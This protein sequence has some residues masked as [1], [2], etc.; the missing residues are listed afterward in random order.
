MRNERVGRF[1]DSSRRALRSRVRRESAVARA[2]RGLFPKLTLKK[3]GDREKINLIGEDRNRPIIERCGE[4]NRGLSR[5]NPGSRGLISAGRPFCARARAAA[6]IRSQRHAVAWLFSV[7]RP[8][9]RARSTGAPRRCA[10]AGWWWTPR[11]VD[12]IVA[13]VVI[14]LDWSRSWRGRARTTPPGRDE[15][16][17]CV[18]RAGFERGWGVGGGDGGAD[19]RGDDRDGDPGTGEREANGRG[20]RRAVGGRGRARSGAARGGGGGRSA[21]A[22]CRSSSRREKAFARGRGDSRDARAEYV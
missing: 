19:A 3:T 11:N 7:R 14:A 5:V 21:K 18:R 9:S 6:S 15:A 22:P 13:L 16:K 1:R 10:R 17:K 4:M 12:A 8:H 2:E 20:A